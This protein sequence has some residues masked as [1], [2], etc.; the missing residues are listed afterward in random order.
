MESANLWENFPKQAQGHCN[1]VFPLLASGTLGQQNV[2][3]PCVHRALRCVCI[4]FR[5][6][7]RVRVNLPISFLATLTA[8]SVP[9]SFHPLTTPLLA[10]YVGRGLATSYEWNKLFC[11]FFS[12]VFFDICHLISLWSN[13]IFVPDFIKADFSKNMRETAAARAHRYT[14]W[15]KS[16][17]PSSFGEK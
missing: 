16:T 14:R 11:Q 12:P 17:F 2:R 8:A 1:Y 3:F 5:Q 13:H 4:Y 6:C 10:I 7:T 15:E 9:R